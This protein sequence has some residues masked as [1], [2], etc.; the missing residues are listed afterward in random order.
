MIQEGADL[1][2]LVG[3]ILT[4]AYIGGRLLNRLRLP[5]V[6]GY[7]FAGILLKLLLSWTGVIEPD[8][9]DVL[10]AERLGQVPQMTLALIA[11]VIGGSL[12]IG[13][14]RRLGRELA[15]I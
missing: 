4:I 14:L 11:F 1:L 12:P 9:L 2:F 3:A 8:R 15:T 13:Q 5:E 7:I 6:T 10:L